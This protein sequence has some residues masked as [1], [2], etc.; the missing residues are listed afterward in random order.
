[1]AADEGVPLTG[2]NLRGVDNYALGGTLSIDPDTEVK[3][4]SP[5]LT[6]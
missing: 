2:Y 3:G 6:L 5:R 1:M 4:V